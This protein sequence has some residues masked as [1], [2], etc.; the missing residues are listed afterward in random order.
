[1]KQ[2]RISDSLSLPLDFVTERIAF[3]ARTGAG[4]SGGM[5]VL[6]EQM[7]D[8]GQF[9]IFLDPKGDAWGIRSDYS[10]LIMGGDHGDVPLDARSGSFVADFLVRDR[11]STVL[12]VSEF[13]EADMVRFV[14]DF[15]E[16]FYRTN[17]AVVHWFLDEADEFAP[18]SGYTKEATKCL[19]AIQRIQRRGRGRGI[20]VKFAD[21]NSV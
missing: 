11:I 4:K 19:G 15:A 16:R 21:A 5:R 10:V 13:S 3:L 20:G 7:C 12:D 2:L 8:A 14:A 17:R 6:A 1:M 9:F 18:Q